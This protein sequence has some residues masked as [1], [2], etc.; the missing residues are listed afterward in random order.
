[1]VLL[2]LEI[3]TLTFGVSVIFVKA[4]VFQIFFHGLGIVHLVL[5]ILLRYSYQSMRPIMFFYGV[6]PFI[7]E[8]MVVF[9]A[10]LRYKIINVLYDHKASRQQLLKDEVD[11][12]EKL[13]EKI[14]K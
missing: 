1:M 14:K 6:I 5:M 2:F 11:R 12:R 10:C 13:F 3:F 4:N 9:M 8:I 7:I